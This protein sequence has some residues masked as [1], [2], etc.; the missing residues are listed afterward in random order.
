MIFEVLCRYADTCGNC[1]EYPYCLVEARTQAEVEKV[2]PPG[3]FVSF[4]VRPAVIRSLPITVQQVPPE[5]VLR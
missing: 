3:A 5:N 2:Y 4:V 1:D